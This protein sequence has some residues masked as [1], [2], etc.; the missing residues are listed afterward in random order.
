MIITYGNYAHDANENWFQIQ[1]RF[2]HNKLGRPQ[3]II[4][5][6]TIYGTKVQLDNDVASLTTKLA[7]LEAAY[8]VDGGDLRVYLNDGSTLTQ[9]YLLNS[10]TVN[11]VQVLGI[12]YVDRDPRSGQS[13][14][15]YVNKRTYRIIL[16][17]E[18]VDADAYPLLSW[19][20]TVIGVGTGGPI[21]VQKGALTGPPQRQIIQQQ[22]SFSAIQIGRAV[23]YLGY[24]TQIASPIWPND[25]HLER[26]RIEPGTPDFGLVRNTGWPISWRYEFEST[27]ALV[28]NPTLF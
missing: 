21:F 20:E 19:E 13:A 6:W 10:G 27:S 2:R 4:N 18:V 23:G 12:S 1:A 25:E 26:R 16:E 24:P 8:S 14:C 15:E 28:G 3:S 11:G 17:A 7:A 5:R 9:H 22:S